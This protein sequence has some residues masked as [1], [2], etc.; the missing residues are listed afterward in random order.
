MSDSIEIGDD[1]VFRQTATDGWARN[2]DYDILIEDQTAYSVH[3]GQVVGE[4]PKYDSFHVEWADG[5]ST[6]TNAA[7][8]ELPENA[9]WLPE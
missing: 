8:L 3:Y 7:K 4:S 2:K 9:E 5:E 6:K 1:V